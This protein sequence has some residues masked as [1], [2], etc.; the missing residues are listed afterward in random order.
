VQDPVGDLV[1]YASTAVFDARIAIWASKAIG[2]GRISN[3]AAQE[4]P[5]A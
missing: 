4:E 2:D 5:T 3:T 1:A